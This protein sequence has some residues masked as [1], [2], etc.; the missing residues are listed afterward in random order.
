MPDQIPA[1]SLA[2]AYMD[3]CGERDRLRAILAAE[4]DAAVER[5]ADEVERLMT[6]K[7]V[8]NVREA[9]ERVLRAA[10]ETP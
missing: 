10:G 2:H 8:W 1:Q 3:V 4:D 5:A 7:T 6:D 9:A